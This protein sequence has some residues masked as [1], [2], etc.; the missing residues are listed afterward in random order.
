MSEGDPSAFADIHSHLVPGVDDGA[1]EVE[2]TLKSVERMTRLGIRK[3]ITTP[4]LN[5][6]L[7]RDPG[8]LTDRLDEVSVAWEEAA[9]AIGRDFP[10]VDF[11]RGHEVML[12]VPEV[13]LTD[14]RMRLA[15]TDFVLLE[16]PRLQ[17]PPGTVNVLKKIVAD[18]YRPIIAHPERYMGIDRDLAIVGQWKDAGALLQVN[19]GSLSGRYGAEPRSHAWRILRRGWGDYMSSDFHGH[20]GMK[21][22]FREAWEELEKLGAIE[23]LRHLCHTNTGRVFKNDA[24]LPVPPLPAERGF[25]SK[26]RNFMMQ[27][28]E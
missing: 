15:G 6:S 18:G 11:R 8:A 3:I 28:P 17:V 23:A 22:Y 9:E 2:D 21:I 25:W 19:Y 16:W 24:P 20:S 27:E 26:V 1:R 10:E 12:D 4:H 13:D 5:A 7:C 14:P